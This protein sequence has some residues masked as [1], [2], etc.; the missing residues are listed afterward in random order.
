MSAKRYALAVHAALC[1]AAIAATAFATHTLAGSAI[2]LG[3]V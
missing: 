2:W 3:P 1:L